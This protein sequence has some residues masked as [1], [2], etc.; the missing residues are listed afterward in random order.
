MKNKILVIT[1]SFDKTVD[2]IVMKFGQE[3]FIRFNV[4]ELHSSFISITNKNGLHL[5]ILSVLLTKTL[6]ARFSSNC[7]LAY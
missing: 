7:H 4:D 3:N 6:L 1:S 5:S 2:Y